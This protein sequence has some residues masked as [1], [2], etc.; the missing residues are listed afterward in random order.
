MNAIDSYAIGLLFLSGLLVLS[1]VVISVVECAVG[2]HRDRQQDIHGF[3][4]LPP[5]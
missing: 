3:D 4:I 1:W 2:S 5:Q